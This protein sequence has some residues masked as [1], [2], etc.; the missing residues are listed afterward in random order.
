MTLTRAVALAG[1][2]STVTVPLAGAA[3][4]RYLTLVNRAHDSVSAVEV[5]PA[6]SDAFAPRALVR[7]LSGGGDAVTVDLAGEGC[8]YGLR[9]TFANGRT[10]VYQD[11]DACRGSRLAI[12]PWPQGRAGQA[13]PELRVADQQR[14]R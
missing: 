4:A 13:R 3:N 5:A 12:Q 2:L 9:F 11:V 7:R 14:P 1:L 6:G 8:R 10:Q